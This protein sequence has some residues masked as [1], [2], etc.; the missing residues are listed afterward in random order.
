M[1]KEKVWKLKLYVTNE[2]PICLYAS[3][4]L[5]RLCDERLKGKCEVDVI[6]ILKDPGAASEEQIVAIPTLVKEFPLPVRR[7]VGDLSD[8]ERLLSGLDIRDISA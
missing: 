1:T 7:V 4:N 5:Q 3:A 2:K 8:T 6:D